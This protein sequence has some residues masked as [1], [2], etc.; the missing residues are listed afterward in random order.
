MRKL[1]VALE[2]YEIAGPV[3]NIDFLKRCC[4][5][6]DFAEGRV[7]TGYISKHHDELFQK[8]EPTQ[9]ALVQA[10]LSSFMGKSKST[11]SSPTQ[12]IWSAPT[13]NF[14]TRTYHFNV[15]GEETA[16]GTAPTTYSVTVQQLKPGQYEVSAHGD[17]YTVT[18]TYDNATRNLTTY[19]PHTRQTSR[20]I[21]SDEG[22]IDSD[23]HSAKIH[24]FTP[25]GSFRLQTATP[26]WITKAL[27]TTE[28]L[29]S[30]LSPMP[31]KI[32]RVSVKPGDTVKKD[33][34]LLVIE[35]M[36]METVIRSPS[37]GLVVKRVVH[38]EG[39]VV[40]SGVELVEFE[41]TDK[42]DA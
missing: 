13:S 27:G 32:L 39:D 1:A 12:H 36:K 28:K 34:P 9:E 26:S 15:D 3:T 31:C 10:A 2:E 37:E 29:N 24:L 22:S 38:N 5:S 41:K 8:H 25:Q 19:F 40:G 35:S 20:V 42:D 7:E 23:H 17:T 6:K 16:P 4:E 18:S 30:L 33:Q 11:N 14:Q 21:S